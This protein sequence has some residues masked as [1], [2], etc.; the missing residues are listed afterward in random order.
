MLQSRLATENIIVRLIRQLHFNFLH[1]LHPSPRLLPLP[2]LLRL[3]PRSLH[4]CLFQSFSQ[5]EEITLVL[6]RG[7]EL[8]LQIL[9]HPT[10]DKPVHRVVWIGK[11]HCLCDAFLLFADTFAVLCAQFSANL[12]FFVQIALTLDWLRGRDYLCIAHRF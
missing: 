5:T 8:R 1:L 9:L 11:I 3:V 2:L 4:L 7:F 12:A 6:R 10:R